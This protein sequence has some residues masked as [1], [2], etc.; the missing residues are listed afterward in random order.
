MKLSIFRGADFRFDSSR[1]PRFRICDLNEAA[2]AYRLRHADAARGM[3]ERW[4][5]RVR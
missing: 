5:L 2:C 1:N 4:T 3:T